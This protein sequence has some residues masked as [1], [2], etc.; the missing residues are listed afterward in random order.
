[1]L[2]NFSEEERLWEKGFK[3]VAGADEVGRGAFA[4]PVVAAAVVFSP[5]TRIKVKINDSKKLTPTQRENADKWIRENALACGVGECPTSKINKLGIV[6]ATRIAFRRAIK[7]LN[8]KADYLLVDAF[9]LPYTRGLKR[10]NQKAIIKGDTKSVS[11]AA[12]SIIA[13]VYRDSLMRGL[14]KK[15]KKYG[16]E[17]NAGYGTK[18]HTDA[19]RKYG[20]TSYHRKE[21]VKN[22]V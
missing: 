2:P 3:Y 9:Y 19:I 1:M 14:S 12:A 4:G 7:K 22:Y 13:K 15:H 11:I 6:K 18:K 21:F 17:A 8:N 16:W 20:I 5:N 10:K